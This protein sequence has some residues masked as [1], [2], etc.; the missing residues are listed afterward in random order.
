VAPCAASAAGVTRKLRER[1]N[2]SMCGVLD[3]PG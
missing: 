2:R 1:K 3:V